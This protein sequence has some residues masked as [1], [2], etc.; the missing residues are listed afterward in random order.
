MLFAP[1]QDGVT[2]PRAEGAMD[3]LEL[4]FRDEYGRWFSSARDAHGPPALLWL[5]VPLD[6]TGA[7]DFKALLQ[8]KLARVG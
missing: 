2:E 6:S 3:A 1:R 7:T 8:A 5:A 4:G